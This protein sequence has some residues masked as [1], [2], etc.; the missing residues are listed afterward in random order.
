ML[1][2]QWRES[3]VSGALS[4]LWPVPSN[5]AEQA[6]IEQLQGRIRRA[7]TQPR[8]AGTY[9]AGIVPYNGV[10]HQGTHEPLITVEIRL[11]IQDRLTRGLA[12]AER[13]PAVS[14]TA[15]DQLDAHLEQALKVTQ[16]CEREYLAAPPAIRRQINQGLFAKLCI[17]SDVRLR[18]PN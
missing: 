7:A 11:R 14:T 18:A 6:R 15:L 1:R 12:D 4:A 13:E 3:A 10:Y 16:S 5:R 9:Y 8:E 17:G 2:N